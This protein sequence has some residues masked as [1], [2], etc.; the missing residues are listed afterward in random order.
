[1]SIFSGIGEM[2][3]DNKSQY[4][5]AGDYVAS[6]VAVR[7][8][9]S[10]KS[11]DDYFVVELTVTESRGEGAQPVGTE[12]AWVCKMGG[13]YPESALRDINSFLNAATGAEDADIDAKF[14]EDA[15]KDD[16]AALVDMQVR[17]NVFEKPTTRGGTFS[18]HTFRPPI[19]DVPF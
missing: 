18:K 8:V 5:T 13:T 15:I 7:L 11:A 9:N 2:K 17:V 12:A 4:L 16:G 19:D 10:K 1:M 14:V 6:I 3:T